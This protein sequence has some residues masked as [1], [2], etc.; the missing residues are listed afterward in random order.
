[1][2]INRQDVIAAQFGESYKKNA[3]TELLK[4]ALKNANEQF[5]KYAFR[6]SIFTS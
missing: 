1:M 5:L 6:Q 3:D 4:F 2:L